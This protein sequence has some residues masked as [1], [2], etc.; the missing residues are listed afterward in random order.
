MSWREALN[1][2][3]SVKNMIRKLRVENEREITQE[4]QINQDPFK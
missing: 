2:V 3:K 4:F 1:E